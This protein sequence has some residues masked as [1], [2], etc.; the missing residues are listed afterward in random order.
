[1]IRPWQI[2]IGYFLCVGL[3]LAAMI[4]VTQN[5]LQLD[6]AEQ[7]SRLRAELEERIGGALWTMDAE[8][9][10]LLAEE[11]ARPARDFRCDSSKPVKGPAGDRPAMAGGA[12]ATGSSTENELVLLRFRVDLDNQ[13]E[14]PQCGPLSGGKASPP[15]EG[16]AAETLRE[17]RDL[18]DF[19]R[20]ALALPLPNDVRDRLELADTLPFPQQSVVNN[21]YAPQ[22]A[23][24]RNDGLRQQF[25]PN[26][27]ELAQQQA[28]GPQIEN[29]NDAPNTFENPNPGA[30]NNTRQQR[31]MAQTMARNSLI[32]R[33]LEAVQAIL[34]A[35]RPDEERWSNTLWIGGH[36]VL[37]RLTIENDSAMILGACLNWNRL[38]ARLKEQ[39]GDA[40]PEFELDP[41]A[42][43]SQ[44]LKHRALATL[45]VRVVTPALDESEIDAWSPIRFTLGLAWVFLSLASLAV[46]ALLIGA[47][48]LSERRASFV[49]AVTHELRSPL[50]T[51]QLYTEM[52]LGGMVPNSDRTTYLKTLKAESE[53]L[54]HLVENV[55]QYSRVERGK[56]PRCDQVV[57]AGEMMERIGPRL[58]E[59]LKQVGMNLRVTDETNNARIQTDPGAVEQIL[60][61][62]ADNASKYAADGE[63]K[64][65]D[66]VWSI[67]G[68]RMVCDARDYGPGIDE[69]GRRQLFRPF[70]KSVNEAAE[71]APGVG[72]G[73]ALCQRLARQLGGSLDL[74]TDVAEAEE[75][76]PGARFRL[77]LGTAKQR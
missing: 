70:S 75:G 5:A 4:S 60:Y 56:G 51:F 11:L 10:S 54:A 33:R 14:S 59:R 47:V 21:A 77:I 19:H 43:E 31:A 72:L 65:F 27:A 63:P 45:P 48:R 52:L 9:S 58:S 66:L 1:M 39:V 29:P 7:V 18:V 64:Q 49:A 42:E 53:R 44:V 40:L 12:H 41:I 55:L 3:A 57:T 36:L 62:L 23:A 68:G 8:V 69:S 37:A 30:F 61:N 32:V 50:T 38:S 46:G 73:L 13:W 34:N 24:L 2:A 71:S 15:A 35:D 76:G 22:R 16:P 17:I 74:R 6:R 20:L 28:A 26:S 67:D 25:G